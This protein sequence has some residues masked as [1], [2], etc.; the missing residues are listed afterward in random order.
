MPEPVQ[1][2]PK[3]KSPESYDCLARK[4]SATLMSAVATITIDQAIST[5]SSARERRT[6]A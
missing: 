6:T 4:T 1:S 5:Q 2:R 3:P